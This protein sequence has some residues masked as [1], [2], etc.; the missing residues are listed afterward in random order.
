MYCKSLKNKK[1]VL[2]KKEFIRYYKKIKTIRL[3]SIIFIYLIK[4]YNFRCIKQ[5]QIINFVFNFLK[6]DYNI[7]R[8]SR[9]Y[10]KI[11]ID[12]IF[13]KYSLNLI[14]SNSYLPVLNI[15]KKDILGE[16]N[17]NIKN[18]LQFCF[19]KKRFEKII[20]ILIPKKFFFF[21]NLRNFLKL[22]HRNLYQK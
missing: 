2:F 21:I 8:L 19:L 20:C 14:Y 15:I 12:Y 11:F 6:K 1:I 4:L 9:L 18:I 16:N 17:D 7:Y 3:F 22:T 13:K 5:K 10:S